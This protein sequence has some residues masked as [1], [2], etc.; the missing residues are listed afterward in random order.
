MY[1]DPGNGQGWTIRKN[2]SEFRAFD[3]EIRKGLKKGVL[4]K[5][6][7]SGISAALSSGG[8]WTDHSPRGLDPRRVRNYLYKYLLCVEENT[9]RR[10]CRSTGKTYYPAASL[11]I[12]SGY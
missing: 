6:G 10:S 2:V 12:C 11:L 8:L 4:K 5:S 3:Q 1:I 9:N 7:A